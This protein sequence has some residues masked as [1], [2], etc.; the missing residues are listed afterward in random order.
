MEIL[1]YARQAVFYSFYGFFWNGKRST[2]RV[3]TPRGISSVV[4]IYGF[5]LSVDVVREEN[6]EK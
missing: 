3:V 2:K 4:E 5:L 6:G 1:S